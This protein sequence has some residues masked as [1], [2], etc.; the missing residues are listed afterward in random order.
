MLFLLPLYI[1]DLPLYE[2]NAQKLLREGLWPYRDWKFEYPP[3]AFPLMVI[4]AWAQ[5]VLGLTGM[6][7]YR[8]LFGLLLLPFDYFLYAALRRR[9]PFPEAAFLYVNL[10]ALLWLLFFDRFDIVIGFLLAL[11]FLLRETAPGD[12]RAALAWGLGGA[13]KLVTLPLAPLPALFWARIE[14]KRVVLQY[15]FLVTAPIAL[16]CALAG[17]LGGGEIS[18]LSH[19]SNRGVQVESIAGSLVMA[20]RAFLGL[21]GGVNTNFGAQHI[22]ELK[23]LVPASRVLFFGSLGF[24]YFF[25]WWGRERRNL[26]AACWLLISG[27]VTFGYVLSPQF[28]L[29]LIPLG[30]CAAAVVPAGPRRVAW[31]VIFSLAV[32]LTGLNFRFYWQYINLNHLAV[33]GV[34][35]R[36]GLLVLLWGLSWRW[37]RRPAAEP[38][39]DSSS[40]I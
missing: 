20:M 25:L 2:Q 22:G 36:N 13:L 26:L 6:E 5:K 40:T 33:L 32:A 14:V 18:F 21:A 12:R 38:L 34:L 3:L 4:P 35:A 28:M 29:W 19:H 27:F 1:S 9:P 24:T 7:S 11:P 31:L 8:S 23:G 10:T 37:M 16:S 30:L 15:F 39:G 17:W